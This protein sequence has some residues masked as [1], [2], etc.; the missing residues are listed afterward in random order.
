MEWLKSVIIGICY[1][2]PT[3]SEEE[4]RCLL[5]NIKYYSKSFTAIMG[6]F[7]NGDIIWENLQANSVGGKMFLDTL[8]DA[9]LTQLMIEPT[10]GG[11]DFR[12]DYE[13]GA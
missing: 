6:D 11:Q 2:S 7:N 5:D 9:F 8:N 3:V 4:E 1:R 13:Y 10:R 12:F